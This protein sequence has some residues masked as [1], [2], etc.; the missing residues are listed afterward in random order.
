MAVG[1]EFTLENLSQLDFGVINAA[2]QREVT[3]AVEDCKDRPADKKQRQVAIVFKFSP[4]IPTS[5]PIECD[6]VAVECEIQGKVP[7]RRTKPYLMT[8]IRGNKLTFNP[9]LPE[10]PDGKTLYDDEERRDSKSK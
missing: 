8:P 9:D 3:R 5:G 4:V 7:L 10:E 1:T 2:F 6:E